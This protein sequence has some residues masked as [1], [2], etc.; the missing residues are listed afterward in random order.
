MSNLTGQL[1]VC[2]QW[3]VAYRVF[4]VGAQ[5]DVVEELHHFVV[6]HLG[7]NELVDD[8]AFGDTFLFGIFVS[9]T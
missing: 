1:Q 8:S 4:T 2:G 9:D 5:I 6:V 7:L 3:S